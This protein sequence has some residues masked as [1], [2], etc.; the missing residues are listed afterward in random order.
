MSIVIFLDDSFWSK[1]LYF[2]FD[3][4]S[5]FKK[6][7]NILGLLYVKACVF[8]KIEE[9]LFQVVNFIDFY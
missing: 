8:F 2:E 6:Y 7:F 3:I 4:L 5:N 1:I 9:L